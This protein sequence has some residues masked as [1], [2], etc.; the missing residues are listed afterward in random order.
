MNFIYEL[1]IFLF[2][3]KFLIFFLK[4]LRNKLNVMIFGYIFVK[5]FHITHKNFPVIELTVVRL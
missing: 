4:I 5:R 2:F 1:L 3:F